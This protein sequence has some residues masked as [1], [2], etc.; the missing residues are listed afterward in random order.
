VEPR[1]STTRALLIF[2]VLGLSFTPPAVAELNG[3]V[4][5]VDID[6]EYVRGEVT[7]TPQS[8]C[9]I[10]EIKDGNGTLIREYVSPTGRV[11]AIAWEGHFVPEM[12]HFLGSLFQ[13]Y[14]TAIY[15]GHPSHGWRQSVLIYTPTLTFENGGHL[16]W[17]FGR[18][19]VPSNV[20]NTFRVEDIR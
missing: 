11:F 15:A 13:E 16:G 18:A 5:S 6:R 1:S 3:T 10:Y 2:C 19:Y 20:P 7:A 12:E 8:G 14:S 17:Y 9:T 4:S